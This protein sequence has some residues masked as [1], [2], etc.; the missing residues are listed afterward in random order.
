MWMLCGR[1]CGGGCECGCVY[2][3]EYGG[4]RVNVNAYVYVGAYVDGMWIWMLA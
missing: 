1:G 2:G 3:H 4:L